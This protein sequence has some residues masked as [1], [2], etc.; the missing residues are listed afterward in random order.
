MIELSCEY[1]SVPWIW[2]YVVIMLC[3]HF[4][5]NSHSL[6]NWNVKK[7]LAQKRRAIWSLSYC[8]GTQTHNHLVRK[9]KLNGLCELTQWLSW[10]VSTY[11]YGAF[12]CMLLSYHIHI[13]EWIHTVYLTECQRT[14]CS[15]QARYLKFKLLQRGS[16][17]QALSSKTNTQPFIESDQVI[18]LSFEYLSAWCI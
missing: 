3:T 9:R 10:V 1:L 8:N 16:N 4:R 18:E 14:P 17:Q 6:F 12:D 15:K 11:L 5:E 13:S 2:L 7:L